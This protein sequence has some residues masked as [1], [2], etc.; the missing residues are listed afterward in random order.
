MAVRKI[1]TCAILAAIGV[2]LAELVPA[3]KTPIIQISFYF[4][5]IV[6]AAIMYGPAYSTIIAILIDVVG[7]LMFGV[8]AFNPIFTVAAA[9]NGFLFGI[10]L[11]RKNEMSFGS[12]IVNAVISAFINATL[13][14]L[15]INSFNIA[16]IT[17]VDKGVTLWA[18]WIALMFPTRAL[19][20]VVMF[21]LQAIV[22]VLIRRLVVPRLAFLMPRKA[23]V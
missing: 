18:R 10:I 20:W 11:Y 21:P 6:L 14:T 2:V 12:T 8:G 23:E 7:T 13:I 1:T 16:L 19:Q 17:Y 3:V 9:I 5:P 15:I 4:V 22:I